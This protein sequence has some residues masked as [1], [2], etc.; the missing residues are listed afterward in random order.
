M[1]W[2]KQSGM[3]YEQVN[4]KQ[5]QRALMLLAIISTAQGNYREAEKMIRQVITDLEETD[6]YLLVMAVELYSNIILSAKK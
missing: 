3:F 4:P 2:L 1:F 5:N 6:N